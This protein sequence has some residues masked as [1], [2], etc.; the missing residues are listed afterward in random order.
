MADIGFQ[1]GEGCLYNI[2]KL[3]V[4]GT[5]YTSNKVIFW[6][7]GGGTKSDIVPIE[8]CWKHYNCLSDH[9]PSYK[10]LIFDNR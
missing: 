3:T 1:E 5:R 8:Y 2:F 7:G 9:N 10:L 6:G 4:F